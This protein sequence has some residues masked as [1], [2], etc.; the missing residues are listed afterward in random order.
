MCRWITPTAGLRLDVMPSEAGVLGFTNPW[1]GE[2]LRT[3]ED[4]E[5]EPGLVVRIVAATS[6]LATKW[7]ARRERGADDPLN[8]TGFWTR[9]RRITC[10]KGIS[11]MPG[12]FLIS[13]IRC[14][15]ASNG[16]PGSRGDFEVPRFSPQKVQGLTDRESN[17]TR[18]Q[19]QTICWLPEAFVLS[20]GP[21]PASPA[22]S[23]RQTE[24]QRRSVAVGH[25]QTLLQKLAHDA[26]G[27]SRR[28]VHDPRCFAA[29]DF[30]AAHRP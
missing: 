3:A 9:R 8:R 13:S 1:Y 11:P 19:G 18:S 30:P 6:H 24:P 4:Y 23:H 14:G 29:R 25:Q 7:A 27:G 5:L 20:R 28:P 26:S 17:L 10:W 12:R 16:S 21:W 2:V 22:S 15:V